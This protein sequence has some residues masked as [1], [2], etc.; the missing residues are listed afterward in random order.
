M[1]ILILFDVQYSQEAVFS[2]EEGLNCQNHFSS[3]S[4][5]PVKTIPPSQISDFPHQVEYPASLT[6][7]W[8]T[9]YIYII[10]PES[11]PKFLGG[12]DG[13]TK[14]SSRLKSSTHKKGGDLYSIHTL[15]T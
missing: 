1:L 5:H 14:K 9:L 6:T 15:L 10:H 3:G 12:G 13:I 8:K 2:F 4:T 7:I 11:N